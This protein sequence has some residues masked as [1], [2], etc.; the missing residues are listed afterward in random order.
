MEDKLEAYLNPAPALP[1]ALSPALH[2]PLPANLI[3]TMIPIQSLT[4]GS[5]QILCF[6]ACAHVLSP[7]CVLNLDLDL[8]FKPTLP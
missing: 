2:L 6:V 7:I 4:P 3:P 5:N 8:N 1:L